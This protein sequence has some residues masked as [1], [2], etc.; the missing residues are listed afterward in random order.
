MRNKEH[1][2]YKY[3]TNSHADN[4][5][6]VNVGKNPRFTVY[7]SNNNSNENN[8]YK[9]FKINITRS[10]EVKKENVVRQ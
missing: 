8:C 3:S 4:Y 10:C 6:H 1:F 5:S 2:K 9:R 7:D